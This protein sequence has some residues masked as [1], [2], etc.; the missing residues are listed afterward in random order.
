MSGATNDTAMR[1]SS[2]LS[3]APGRGCGLNESSVWGFDRMESTKL[4]PEEEGE[5]GGLCENDD[6]D[7]RNLGKEAFFLATPGFRALV[8]EDS[9]GSEL[10]EG[11][12]SR[13]I[14][15]GKKE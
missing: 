5:E 9:R 14:G 15:F 2:F 3:L 1:S 10:S 11:E 12:G 6:G 13:P 7:E 8:G 4:L